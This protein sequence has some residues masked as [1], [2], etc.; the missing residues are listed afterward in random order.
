MLCTFSGKAGSGAARVLEIWA[1]LSLGD[2]CVKTAY[3]IAARET[4]VVNQDL[5]IF[6]N[7]KGLT[8]N[9]FMET[10]VHIGSSA[11]SRR[12]KFFERAPS[13]MH[14]MQSTRGQGRL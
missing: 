3:K 14:K 11:K 13:E 4:F 12:R 6:D 10:F 9:R 2:E 5:A 8:A 7:I 1:R